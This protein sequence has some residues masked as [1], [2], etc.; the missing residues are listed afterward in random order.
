MTP[1]GHLSQRKLK[2]RNIDEKNVTVSDAQRLF[3]KC[4]KLVSVGFDKNM[5]GQ[6]LGSATIIYLKAKSAVAAIKQYNGAQIDDRVLK[7]EYAMPLDTTK[8]RVETNISGGK[9]GLLSK[10][11]QTN[12]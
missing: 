5:H 2:V 1:V 6:Y 12:K 10:R 11:P 4:G 9:K 7:V 8:P 3:S